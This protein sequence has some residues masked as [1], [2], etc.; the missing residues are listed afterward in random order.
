MKAAVKLRHIH[1]RFGFI[2]ILITSAT[3]SKL[4]LLI[5]PEQANTA[6]PAMLMKKTHWRMCRAAV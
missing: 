6:L 4:S 3:D 2:V 1:L 5:Q